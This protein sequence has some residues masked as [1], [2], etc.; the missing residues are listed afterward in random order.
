MG[1]GASASAG[2]EEISED[3]RLSMHASIR[4][5][6]VTMSGK[7]KYVDEVESFSPSGGGKKS[8]NLL[9]LAAGPRKKSLKELEDEEARR[10]YAQPSNTSALSSSSKPQSKLPSSDL[11]I[12]ASA[13]WHRIISHSRQTIN[14]VDTDS[15]SSVQRYDLSM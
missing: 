2:G 6:V 13:H 7:L 11:E 1:A 15:S 4:P 14:A 5:T 10:R 3:E 12:Q 9:E 8:P